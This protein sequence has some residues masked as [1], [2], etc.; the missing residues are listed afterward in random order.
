MLLCES[1]RWPK[2]KIVLSVLRP[3]SKD[4]VKNTLNRAK[5]DIVQKFLLLHTSIAELAKPK[6]TEAQS[7]LRPE[8]GGLLPGNKVGLM[9]HMSN[10]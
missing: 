8:R 7:L 5:D 1:S 3:F 9:M 6:S 2:Q 4:V 10:N